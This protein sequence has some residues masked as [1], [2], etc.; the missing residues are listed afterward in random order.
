MSSAPQ[1]RVPFNAAESDPVSDPEPPVPPLP[2]PDPGVFHHEPGV[3]HH[4][5]GE[6]CAPADT[7]IK[8]IPEKDRA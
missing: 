8:P 4:E 3:F 2:E 5:P 6:P 1:L 7:P